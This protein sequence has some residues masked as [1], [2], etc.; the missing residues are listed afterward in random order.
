MACALALL[1]AMPGVAITA[2]G[3]HHGVCTITAFGAVGGNRSSDAVANAAAVQ[4]AFA[5][6]DRV[7]VPPG[8]FKIAPIELPSHS[9]LWLDSGASLVGSDVW[10]DYG[11]TYFMPRMG[12]ALQMKPLLSATN[13]TNVTVT[14]GNGTI[15]GNGWFA[16][17]ATNWSSPEC[18]I[19]KHCAPDVFF[20]NA[21]HK[22]RP[23]HAVTFIRSTAVS[24]VNV[25]ITNPA[26]WGLQHFYCNDSFQSHVTI[27][28]PRWTREIAGFMPWSVLR[29]TV[30][31]SYVAVGD[32]AVAI[33]SGRDATTAEV[34]FRRLFV[35]GRSVAIG[36]AD[37]GNVTDVLF[38][39]CTI[40]DDGGSSPWAFKIKMHVNVASHVS[41]IVIR[42]TRFGNITSNSWQD[43]GGDGGTAIQMGMNY[44]NVPIDPRAGQPTISNISFINVTAT[45]T[46]TVASLA[47]AS[48]HSIA[49]LYFVGCN[50]HAT[51][52]TPWTLTNVD[53][54]T[55]TSVQTTPPFPVGTPTLGTDYTPLILKG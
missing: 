24:V 6:C 38:D 26:F 9:T 21:S 19:H 36:S 55:C 27:L 43:P 28:A 40:G 29:Y 30:L 47:G 20:G 17:P 15:D 32:D 8:V 11:V 45:Q 31:D 49:R 23:P 52:P 22:L 50:F 53:T 12:E 7:R 48:P 14:G 33:M 5:A 54:S 42:N 35:R 3:D 46:R 41:G 37:F 16:W 39:D 51:S 13:A 34:I 25:T 18:G 44:G 2:P 10:Q 1:A 4:A